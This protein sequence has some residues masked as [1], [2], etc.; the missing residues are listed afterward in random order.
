MKWMRK[1]RTPSAACERC[2]T[3]IAPR[4]AAKRSSGR[5]SRSSRAR[6]A[7]SSASRCPPRNTTR[8]R[9]MPRRFLTGSKVALCSHSTFRM[10]GE[11]MMEQDERPMVSAHYTSGDLG[12]TLL[13]ALRA[14][15]KDPD[16]LT[17]DDLT[18]V[19]QFHLGGKAATLSLIERA[20]FRPGMHVLD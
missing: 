10:K 18:P 20:G 19:D 16:A 7:T 11:A 5:A 13:A 9:T 17:L 15:G 1:A 12:E 4:S 3:S 14:T 8:S 6:A 2:G